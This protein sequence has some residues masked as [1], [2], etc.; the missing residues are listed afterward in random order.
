[1]DAES[2]SM[3][4]THLQDYTQRLTSA[5]DRYDWAMRTYEETGDTWYLN[6]A[7]QI[8]AGISNQLDHGD[9]INSTL[10]RYEVE[11]GY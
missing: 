4:N 6:H 2:L 11:A 9:W 8:A 3:L 5:N 1:M 7:N 10:D